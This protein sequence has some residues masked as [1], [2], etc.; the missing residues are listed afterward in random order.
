MRL[1]FENLLCGQNNCNFRNHF[2]SY[3][4][5]SVDCHIFVW[6]KFRWSH[7][8]RLIMS[9]DLYLSGLDSSLL[10]FIFFKFLLFFLKSPLSLA[11]SSMRMEIFYHRYSWTTFFFYR[12]KDFFVKKKKCSLGSFCFKQLILKVVWLDISSDL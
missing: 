8:H 12:S 6:K 2:K 7:R 1:L 9:K 5:W 4:L 3:F 10:Y 11:S